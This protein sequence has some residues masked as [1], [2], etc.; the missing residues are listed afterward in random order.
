MLAIVYF[1][2]Q[3][4]AVLLM[5]TGWPVAALIVA[6]VAIALPWALR[7]VWKAARPFKAPLPA[8]E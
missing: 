2:L 6:G 8:S 1:V 4:V 5:A 3:A 7:K